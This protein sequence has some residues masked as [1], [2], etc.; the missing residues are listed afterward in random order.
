MK[1]TFEGTANLILN[2]TQGTNMYPF[3]KPGEE[4]DLGD[5]QISVFYD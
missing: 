4:C 3:H 5:K 1:K 2:G